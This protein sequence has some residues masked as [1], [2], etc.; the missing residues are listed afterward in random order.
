[1]QNSQSARLVDNQA[2]S[3]GRDPRR[4]RSMPIPLHTPGILGQGPESGVGWVGPWCAAKTTQQSKNSF[5][6]GILL[7]QQFWSCHRQLCRW[8]EQSAAPNDV[9]RSPQRCWGSLHGRRA[10]WLVWL[11]GR[12]V[13][14]AEMYIA[15][16]AFLRCKGVWW[17]RYAKSMGVRFGRAVQDVQ[18]QRLLL[19][20]LRKLQG[21]ALSGVGHS[22]SGSAGAPWDLVAPGPKDNQALPSMVADLSMAFPPHRTALQTWHHSMFHTVGLVGEPES[23]HSVPPPSRNPKGVCHGRS[24]MRQ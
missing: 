10:T 20:P 13:A 14:I 16:M 9:A 22:Q 3:I 21:E 1:M 2:W 5:L 12:R 11:L 6:L 19:D 8:V 17:L 15:E 4:P 24:W 18:G 7:P 23:A